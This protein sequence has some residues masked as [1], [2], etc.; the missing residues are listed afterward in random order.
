MKS[1]TNIDAPF[2]V[3]V[4]DSETISNNSERNNENSEI[5]KGSLDMK[6]S[7]EEYIFEDI[8]VET[9]Q[10]IKEENNAD[11]AEEIVKDIREEI[12]TPIEEVGA[13]T[14][15]SIEEV[16]ATQKKTSQKLVDMIECCHT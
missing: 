8:K 2:D 15:T 10:E 7:I 12:M 6:S 16:G 3:L 11:K 13:K 14:M 5:S 9:S 4:H 1:A